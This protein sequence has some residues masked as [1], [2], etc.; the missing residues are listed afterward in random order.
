MASNTF[1]SD[2]EWLLNQTGPKYLSAQPCP[3]VPEERRSG[4]I[5]SEVSQHHIGWIVVASQTRDKIREL[6]SE[7]CDI[8]WQ[9]ED[10][11]EIILVVPTSFT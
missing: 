9:L 6:H 3:E 4:D 5:D 2:I 10:E 11:V 1:K 8:L 7:C